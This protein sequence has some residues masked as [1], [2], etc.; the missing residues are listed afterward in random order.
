V[1]GASWPRNATA[2]QVHE[3]AARLRLETR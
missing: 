3:V 2:R 1:K